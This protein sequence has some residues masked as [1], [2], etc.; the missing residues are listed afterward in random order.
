MTKKYSYEAYNA[1]RAPTDRYDRQYY[2]Y[3]KQG[4]SSSSYNYYKNPPGY[5]F[6]KPS[7]FEKKELYNPNSETKQASSQP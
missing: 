1:Y 2:D 5:P 3:Q 4:S 7:Q 6:P